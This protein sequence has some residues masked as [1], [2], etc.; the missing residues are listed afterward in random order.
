MALVGGVAHQRNFLVESHF[1]RI[2]LP[3]PAEQLLD[4]AGC[5]VL[6]RASHAET[7]GLLVKAKCHYSGMRY[8]QHNPWEQ[9]IAPIESFEDSSGPWAEY[10]EM[11]PASLS[12]MLSLASGRS[13]A[14]LTHMLLSRDGLR[15]ASAWSFQ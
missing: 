12:V 9:P 7:R 15:C 8:K 14:R 10:R 4:A 5:L 2:E 3:I 13:A 6:Q 11:G 1:A